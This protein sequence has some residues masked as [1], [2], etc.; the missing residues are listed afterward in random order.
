MWNKFA[1]GWIKGT[2]SLPDFYDNSFL[3]EEG[4][5]GA[6]YIK[7]RSVKPFE[8]SDVLDQEDE[9]YIDMYDESGTLL[10]PVKELPGG[11]LGTDRSGGAK[12]FVLRFQ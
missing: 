9:V 3:H 4:D 10:G 2:D 5:M 6:A 12:T 8:V 7:L 11:M 1:K